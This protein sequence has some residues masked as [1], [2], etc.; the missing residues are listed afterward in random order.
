MGCLLIT[1]T[2]ELKVIADYAVLSA[3][4]RELGDGDWLEVQEADAVQTRHLIRRQAILRVTETLDGPK[5][6]ASAR[7]LGS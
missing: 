5:L 6:P 2:G 4:L 1:A 3:Q 7:I